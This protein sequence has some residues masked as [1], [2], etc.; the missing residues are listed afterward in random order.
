VSR[1]PEVTTVPLPESGEGTL[2]EK[3]LELIRPRLGEMHAAAI[4]PGLTTHP[5]TVEA[6][7][8]LLSEIEVPLVI[9]ADGL[10]AL[11]GAT[12]LL[13]ARRAPTVLTPH[14]G[15]LS[16]LLERPAAEIDADRLSAARAAALRLGCVVLLKGP[17]TVIANPDGSAFVNMTGGPALAQGGTGDV[18]TGMIAAL[19]AQLRV[20]DL[21]GAARAA[22]AAAWIHGRA[23]DVVAGRVA[24]H[25]AS[26][27]M[28]VEELPAILHE[29]AG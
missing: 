26:A 21:S 16:R 18:L 22:A 6:V 25:P 8:A 19:M 5:R 4:G 29:V 23:G 28:L 14:T 13:G 27:S 15:E 9:D 11:A 24:P 20:A 10:N 2:D 7:R 17:G 12:Q 3:A 1:I